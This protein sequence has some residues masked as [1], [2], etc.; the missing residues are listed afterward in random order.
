MKKYIV[1]LSELERQSLTEM[2]QKGKA[3]ARKLTRVRILLKANVGDGGA[4]WKDQQISEALDVGITTVENTRKK[5]V[6]EGFAIAIHGHTQ[7]KRRK[8]IIGG[9]EEAHLISLACSKAPEGYAKWTLRLLADKM[10][11]LSYVDSISH[12][13]LRTA[14]KKMN[15]SLG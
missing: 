13:T 8:K 10:V 14:L 11:E 1:S 15:L 12:E 2:L 4:G 9:E 5:F 3:A 6:M 7:K